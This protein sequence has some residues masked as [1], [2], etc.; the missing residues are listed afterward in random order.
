MT[1]FPVVDAGVSQGPWGLIKRESVARPAGTARAHATYF[2]VLGEDKGLITSVW[3]ASR[4]IHHL[5]SILCLLA[6]RLLSRKN[7]GGPLCVN[8]RSSGL[9]HCSSIYQKKKPKC[10]PPCSAL[11]RGA[12][13]DGQRPALISFSREQPRDI[14]AEGLHLADVQ[15]D[16]YR[17]RLAAIL[18]HIGV[19]PCD[20]ARVTRI[21][22]ATRLKDDP[23]SNW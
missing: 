9:L 5:A 11:R 2:K 13:T 8:L 16:A 21:L 6:G 22:P 18:T 14:R 10:L 4:A 23:V 19:Q 20:G 15:I 17:R 3:L 7:T 1:F 12:V